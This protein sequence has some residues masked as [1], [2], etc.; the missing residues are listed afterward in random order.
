MDMRTPAMF[1]ATPARPEMSTE[2]LPFTIRRVENEDSLKKAVAIRHAA[3]A[4]HVPE[5]AR[6]LALPEACDYEED[7]VVLLAEH[8]LDGTPLGT[9][10]IR[11]NIHHPLHIEESVVLPE[12][13]QGRNLGEVERLGVG[14]GRIGHM[15]KVALVKAFFE[16]FEKTGIEYAVIAGRAPVDRHYE[17][18]MFTDVFGDKEMVPLRHAGNM[19]HRVMAF[20]IAS[21]EARWTAAKHPLL[22]FFRHTHH[23]DIDVGVASPVSLQRGA[24]ATP[25]APHMP[26]S[27][28]LGQLAAA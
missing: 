7:T 3:Y 1:S 15:V 13:L 20:E 2:R 26:I 11:T 10:R 8:K 21:G 28:P 12:W 5:F 24:Q 4:R 18:L 22:K 25:A 17:Q 9:A 27:A 16:Y 19:P 14:E 6:S 23:P